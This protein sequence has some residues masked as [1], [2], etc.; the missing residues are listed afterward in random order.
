MDNAQE[1]SG[2][3]AGIDIA[4]VLHDRSKHESGDGPKG[5]TKDKSK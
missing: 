4:K 3:K 2:L 1:A 5:N